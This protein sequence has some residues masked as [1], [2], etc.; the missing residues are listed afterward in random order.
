MLNFDRYHATM[1]NF[2]L[3][4]HA[5]LPS[6][7][8]LADEMT[9]FYVTQRKLKFAPCVGHDRLKA[10]LRE[11]ELDVP[12]LDFL[13]RDKANLSLLADKLSSASKHDFEVRAVTPGTIMFSG[14]PI[15]DITGPFWFTQMQEVKFEHAFDE[16]MTVASRALKVRRAAG[17]KH[18]SGFSLRR[19]GSAERSL[20]VNK[21][22]YIGGFDDTSFME[23]AYQLGINP[24]GT[25]AHYYIQA[26]L[27]FL[28]AL[29]PERDPQG[30]KKHFEQ[31]AFEKW[32]DA[33]PNGTTLL[34]DTLLLKHG[35]IH[36]IR[37]AKSSDARRKALKFV[38][39]DSG[40]LPK[41][42]LWIRRM[43]DANNMKD[44]GIMVTSDLDDQ[45]IR[46]IVQTCC[47]VDGFGVGTKL[48]AEVESVAG[49]IFKMCKIGKQATMKL[50]EN[51]EKGTLPGKT[52]VWRF[53]DNEG[54]YIKDVIT[55][56]MEVPLKENYASVAALL[57]PF[58]GRNNPD[59]WVPNIHDQRQFVIEQMKHFRDIENYPVELSSSLQISIANLRKRLLE[60][61]MGEEDVVMVDYPE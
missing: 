15:A 22:A 40:D 27:E 9:T 12:H 46:E 39:I 32:L 52:Q 7:K 11:T 55:M 43:L 58:F 1:G 54:F 59:P 31:I 56:D 28:Y 49:V 30:R 25:I 51:P 38:R 10:A 57:R 23:A 44:V 60:D 53:I 35:I 61:E 36:A 14:E 6:G 3:T 4:D 29:H 2:S 8:L 18:V 13:R 17:D 50:S 45:K 37:A 19:D 42:T 33:N 5:K 21:Y 48:I 16:P 47:D 26:F 20:E 34:L 41:N 24:V